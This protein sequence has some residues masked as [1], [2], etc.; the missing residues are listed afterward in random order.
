MAN[1]LEA[2]VRKKF[3]VHMAQG[4]E[5]LCVCRW[6]K[7]TSPSLYINIRKAVYYCFSCG[8]SGG[9]ESLRKA[10]RLPP[11]LSLTD[12]DP[13]MV[14]VKTQAMIDVLNDDQPGIPES[15]LRAYCATPT[16]YWASRGLS[17][18]V[19]G[20]AQLG[21]DMKANAGTIPFRSHSGS[22]L[23]VIRRFLDPEAKPRYRYPTGAP[24]SRVLWGSWMLPVTQSVAVCEGALDAVALIDAGVPAVG[25]L[26][27]RMSPHQE[28]LFHQLGANQV[29]LFMDN[30]SAGAKATQ[31][32]AERLRRRYIVR[33]AKYEGVKD[34]GELSVTERA[35]A[36][37]GSV[38]YR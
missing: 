2:E 12:L 4:D 35:A 22:L 33:I 16:D 5:L 30:D 10:L 19:V 15:M 34:P 29:V 32:I 24:I 23:G 6:H 7:D 20:L 31:E 1:R 11:G 13:S 37:D 3:D 26:G 21:F 17:E 38:L 27:C 9:E 36:Y 18:Q 14:R 25:L 28:R 8:A